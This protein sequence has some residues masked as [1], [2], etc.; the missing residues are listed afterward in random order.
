MSII[1]PARKKNLKN[2]KSRN[3]NQQVDRILQHNDFLYCFTY[4]HNENIRNGKILKYSHDFIVQNEHD[5]SG[6][7]DA[8]IRN[9]LLYT[10]CSDRIEILNLN[11]KVQDA[12][13]LNSVGLCITTTDTDFF[14]GCIDGTLQNSHTNL[15]VSNHALWAVSVNDK[16]I[17]TGGDSKILY[18][19][20]DKTEKLSLNHIIIS[21]F[22]KWPYL[23]IGTYEKRIF[24]LDLRINEIVEE[25]IL[26]GSPWYIHQENEKII[27]PAMYDGF[28]TSDLDFARI[29]YYPC[30]GLIYDCCLWSG[31][32]FFASFYEKVMYEHKV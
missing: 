5:S 30:D 10:V 29:N 26:P 19:I 17:Y 7:L 21:L 18:I 15:K 8:V 22:Q 3:I 23:F 9:N 24:R 31:S 28:M 11:L 4:E 14:A 20:N 25:Y 1:I 2:I 32:I 16:V 6:C 13:L 12:K 27:M